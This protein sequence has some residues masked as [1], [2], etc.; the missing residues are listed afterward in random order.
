M[1]KIKETV[2][3]IKDDVENAISMEWYSLEEIINDKKEEL[4][5]EMLDKAMDI[6]HIEMGSDFTDEDLNALFEE[7]YNSFE[8]FVEDTIYTEWDI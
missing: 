6:L 7:D 2:E 8:E 3:M 1:S 4:K 5:D